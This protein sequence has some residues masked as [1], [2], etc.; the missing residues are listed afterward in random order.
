[1]VD[2]VLS[3]LGG[4]GGGFGVLSGRGAG[5][6]T[7]AALGSDAKVTAVVVGSATAPAGAVVGV[8]TLDA[9]GLARVVVVVLGRRRVVVVVVDGATA[10]AAA[11]SAVLTAGVAVVVVVE[12]AA[13]SNAARWLAA[14]SAA[15]SRRAKPAWRDRLSRST[16]DTR[17]ANRTD[18]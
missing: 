18:E 9:F 3:V 15:W 1:M 14:T 17:R 4:A 11:S 6:H 5:P 10:V 12:V 7:R 2:V 8:L 13:A 16:F